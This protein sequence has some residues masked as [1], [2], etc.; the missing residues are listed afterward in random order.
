M[1]ILPSLD[2]GT[3][4][5]T[6]KVARRL[7]AF[8]LTA[9][10]AASVAAAFAVYLSILDVERFRLLIGLNLLDAVFWA[11]VPLLHRFGPMVATVAFGASVYASNLAITA[12]L[13]TDSGVQLYYMAVAALAVVFIGFARIVLCGIFVAI[14]AGLHILA[15]FWLP[16]QSTIIAVEPWLADSTYI[17]SVVAVFGLLFAIVFYGLR[18][19]ARAEAVAEREYARSEGLLVNILPSAIAERLK[20]GQE[21][22]IADNFASASILFVDL[23]GFTSRA[24]HMPPSELIVFLNGVFSRF[25][26]LVAKYGVEKIKTIGD[27]YMVAAGLPETRPDHADAAADLALDMLAAAADVRDPD[28]N[29]VAFRIGIGSGPVVAGVVGTRKFAYDVWGDTV[30]VAARMESQGEPGR[31]QISDDTHALLSER[32]HCEE[33]GVIEVRGRGPLKTWFL[34]GRDTGGM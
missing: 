1:S 15:H 8:N 29:P 18:Q 25:D 7:R 5:Y 30:N 14:A 4:A 6:D 13:G 2:F 11:A 22:I 10:T 26:T 23:V 16:A 9:W 24:S 32:F 33:R 19:T 27:A 20:G 17:V 21:S 31:I 3:R 34:V 28:G 12:F